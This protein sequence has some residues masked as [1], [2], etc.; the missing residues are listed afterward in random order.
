MISAAFAVVLVCLS[1]LMSDWMFVTFVYCVE[2]SKRILKLFSPS[3]SHHTILVFFLPNLIAIFRREPPNG[4]VEC[5]G[6][7]K[8]AIFDQYLA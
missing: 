4:G 5:R 2:T 3:S 8:I 6:Y 1:V 7:E